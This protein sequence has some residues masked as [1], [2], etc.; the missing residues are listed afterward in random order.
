KERDWEQA[1]ACLEEAVTCWKENREVDQ[2]VIELALNQKVQ[3]HQQYFEQLLEQDLNQAQTH[4]REAVTTLK[5]LNKENEE[6]KLYYEAAEKLRKIKTSAAND[7]Y[8][9]I[10][11]RLEPVTSYDPTMKEIFEMSLIRLAFQAIDEKEFSAAKEYYQKAL[12]ITVKNK[13][14]IL[15]MLSH[16]REIE[17]ESTDLISDKLRPPIEKR[18]QSTQISTHSETPTELPSINES[19]SHDQIRNE[20]GSYYQTRDYEV[21]YNERIDTVK[22]DL[23]AQKRRKRI[24]ILIAANPAEAAISTMLLKGI[25]PKRGL[26]K[27]IYLIKG[28]SQ[29]LETDANISIINR[30]KA[31]PL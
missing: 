23:I 15:S 11:E 1:A 9:L 14:R 18:S 12:M 7:Y 22:V 20:I 27:V 21:S 3:L 30:L 6:L 10:Y 2:K 24:I 25:P 29:E 16:I 4:L 5:S 19:V 13:E 8:L 17:S 26:K 28:N 31:L